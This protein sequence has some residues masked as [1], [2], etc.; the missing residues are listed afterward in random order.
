MHIKI[1][2]YSYTTII[3][4]FKKEKGRKEGKH[5]SYQ[6]LVGMRSY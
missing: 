4:A 1:T 2:G 6:A 3:M 5:Y